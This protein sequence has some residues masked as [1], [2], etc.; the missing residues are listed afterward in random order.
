MEEKIPHEIV[1][2]YGRGFKCYRWVDEE[3]NHVGPLYFSTPEK[4][5][6]WKDEQNETN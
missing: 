3:G 4:A 1:E 6:E 2:F 5:Q